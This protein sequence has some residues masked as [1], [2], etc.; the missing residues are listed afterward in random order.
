M[1]LFSKFILP[2]LEQ[3]IVNIEPQ[4]AEFVLKQMKIAA[5]EVI[6]WIEKKAHIDVNGDGAI[7]QDKD[8]EQNG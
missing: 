7:G 2:K 8:E 4:I 5:H 3:E 6:E 1:S